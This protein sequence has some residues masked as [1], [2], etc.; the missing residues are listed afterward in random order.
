MPRDHHMG[1]QAWIDQFPQLCALEPA[2]IALLEQGTEIHALPVGSYA[3]TVGSPCNRY[4]MLL[5]GTVRVQHTAEN[6]REIVLYRIGPGESCI[7]TAAGL[8]SHEDYAAEGVAETD[9]RAAALVRDAF[10]RLLA[11]SPVFRSFV[12]QSYASRLT[13]LLTLVEE[14]AFQRVDA[15]LAR[16]LIVLAGPDGQIETTHQR[17]AQ[18]LGTAREVVSRQLKEFERRTW[19]SQRRG[20][21]TIHAPTA[22]ADLAAQDER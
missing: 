10:D 19:I 15:R 1:N 18:E 2:A 17:L 14:V 20:W 16:R 12:F 8:L 11:G 13:S 22:L 21:I 5:A 6:G 7:L 3:F 9:V 4:L